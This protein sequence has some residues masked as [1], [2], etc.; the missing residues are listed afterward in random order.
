M[1]KPYRVTLH[2]FEDDTSVCEVAL[3]EADSFRFVAEQLNEGAGATTPTMSIE[4]A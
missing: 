4:E 1:R 3:T 2:G